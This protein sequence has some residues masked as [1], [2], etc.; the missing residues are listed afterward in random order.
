MRCV[1]VYNHCNRAEPERTSSQRGRL[2]V[3]PTQ[4]PNCGEYCKPQQLTPSALNNTSDVHV[5]LQAAFEQRVAALEGG[6]AAVATASGMAAQLTAILGICEV[7][8][9]LVVSFVLHPHLVL[10]MP[11]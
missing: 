11:C 5:I 7:G 2:C 3:L 9:H 1:P 8:N 10:T 6:V 4:Q